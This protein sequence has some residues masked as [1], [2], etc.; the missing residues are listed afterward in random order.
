MR[1]FIVIVVAAL[2]VLCG[3]GFYVYKTNDV[4]ETYENNE[5]KNDKIFYYACQVLLSIFFI[6]ISNLINL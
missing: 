2:V 6:E 4:N 1:K 3:V 5:I